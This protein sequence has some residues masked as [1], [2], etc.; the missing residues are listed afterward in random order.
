MDAC[1]ATK[2]TRKV[3]VKGERT[4]LAAET[5]TDPMAK[6]SRHNAPTPLA[7]AGASFFH[8]FVSWVLSLTMSE[9]FCSD[10][11]VQ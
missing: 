4:L 5:T 2:A 3:H 11:K 7:L 8:E 6:H 9:Q 1:F 10:R